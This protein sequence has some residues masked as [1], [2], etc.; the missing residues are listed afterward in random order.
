MLFKMLVEITTEVFGM[1]DV[2]IKGKVTA[3]Q[4]N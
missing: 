1:S 2:Q 3:S 4:A